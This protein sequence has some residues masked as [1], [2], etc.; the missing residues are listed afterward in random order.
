MMESSNSSEE[1]MI[2]RHSRAKKR[3]KDDR[4]VNASKRIRVMSHVPDE[5]CN[6]KK[7][8]F[9]TIVKQERDVLIR[10][11]NLLSDKINKVLICV[12]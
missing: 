3:S 8:C 9:K 1:N 7:Q 5:D 2:V 4:L 6:C 11:F 12:P 10:N